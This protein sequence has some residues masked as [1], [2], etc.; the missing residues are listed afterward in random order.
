LGVAY[1]PAGDLRTAID[2]LH[3]SDELEGSPGTA[4]NAFFLAMAYGK[5]GDKAQAL[6]WYTQAL[7]WMDKYERTNDELRRFRAEAEE[8]LGISHK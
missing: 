7:Q 2:A 5:L 4:F 3:K 8:L 1:Y 6:K